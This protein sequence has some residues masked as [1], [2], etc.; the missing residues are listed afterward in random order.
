MI[1]SLAPSL[2]ASII[3]KINVDDLKNLLLNMTEAL[4]GIDKIDLRFIER[5]VRKAMRLG[6]WARLDPFEKSMVE[7]LR[8]FLKRGGTVISREIHKIVAKIHA[9]VEIYSLKGKAILFGILIRMKSRRELGDVEE[10][11][12]EGLQFINR[13]IPY[14]AL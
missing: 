14:R 5:L 13:P 3:P 4:M 8:R 1:I 9:E 11:M 12:V 2:A 10:L 6:A 7:A